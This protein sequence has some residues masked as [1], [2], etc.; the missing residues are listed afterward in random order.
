MTE[1][2]L[3]YLKMMNPDVLETSGTQKFQ[4]VTSTVL[5]Q[6]LEQM[7]ENDEEMKI[8]GDEIQEE[9]YTSCDEVH[10]QHQQSAVKA[11]VSTSNQQ[12]ILSKKEREIKEIEALLRKVQTTTNNAIEAASRKKE[13][14]KTN[15]SIKTKPNKIVEDEIPSYPIQNLQ[16]EDDTNILADLDRII[17]NLELQQKNM[18]TF[19]I[20][21]HYD[22][23]EQ[24]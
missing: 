21:D 17:N 4:V 19:G 23:E 5:N 22:E 3:N 16:Q 24:E 14:S 7:E 1:G 15:T 10:T 13:Q 6:P 11:S 20:V 8:Q 9:I 18:A 12:E 2:T